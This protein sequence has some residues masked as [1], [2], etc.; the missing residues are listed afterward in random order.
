MTDIIQWAAMATG[1]VAAVMIAGK[2]RGRVTGWGFALFVVSS[3]LWVAFG[4]IE[5][6]TPLTIQNAVLLVVNL[7]GVWRYLIMKEKN[8]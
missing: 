5:S 4:V 8:G 6:E 1:V 7:V 3:I 2:F